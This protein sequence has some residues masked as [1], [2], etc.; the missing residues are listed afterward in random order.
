MDAGRGRLCPCRRPPL[1]PAPL[2]P[3]PAEHLINVLASKA[4][5]D[6]VAPFLGY[7][8]VETP[9][10]HAWGCSWASSIRV[11]GGGACS[12]MR[13]PAQPP[14]ACRPRSRL[15]RPP[16]PQPAACCLPAGGAPDQG[17]LAGVG[18]RG[19]QDAGV[20]PQA[21]GV[22][23]ERSA[24]RRLQQADVGAGWLPLCARVHDSRLLPGAA[25]ASR[26]CASYLSEHPQPC[27]CAPALRPLQAR[28]G[29]VPGH[30]P[31]RERGA[32]GADRDE[33]DL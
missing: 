15:T 24:Q 14:R 5:G 30:G 7:A 27:P 23:Y 20:L 13:L 26:A 25:P 18:V 21:V 28:Q 32:G 10:R 29:A 6:A 22:M 2:P 33:A 11:P 31:G 9:V 1:V 16:C 4:A 3:P 19:G 8:L 12:C 17:A